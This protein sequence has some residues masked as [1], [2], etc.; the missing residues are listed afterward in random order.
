M[1]RSINIKDTVLDFTT[2][3]VMGILNVTPDSFSDGG[4]FDTV[5]SAVI[6]ANKLSD[7]GATILDIGGYSSRPGA[8]D[9][10]E[11]EEIDRVLPVIEKI[12]KS[13]DVFVSIDTFR[14]E[15]AKAAISA[16]AHIVNDISA[17][18]DDE[19]M[20]STVAALNVPYIAM[21]K[22]GVSATMQKNPTYRN[23]VEEV[24]GYLLKKVD[25]CNKAGISDVIIDPGFGFGKTVEHNYELLKDLSRLRECG[26]P[27]LA[28]LSRKSMI[29]KVLECEPLEAINGT[30]FL[31]SFALGGGAN[32][33]RVHDVREAVECLKLWRKLHY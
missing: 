19:A 25:E 9:V 13:I 30:T 26:V 18:E 17:G 7:E 27:I 3:K 28:G 1:K 5:D 23:V 14:S 20:I 24:V 29:Y 15:V 21:H 8:S 6:Q 22:Q 12:S 31:H 16:G 33:L 4:K 10:S 11:A 2:P 32:I